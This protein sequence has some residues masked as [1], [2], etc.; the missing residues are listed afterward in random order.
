MNATA[1]IGKAY[2]LERLTLEEGEILF[3]EGYLYDL[4]ALAN[5]LAEQKVPHF[6]THATFVVDRN[7]NYTN[8]CNSLCKFCAFYRLPGDAKEGYVR[9]MDEIFHKIEELVAIGGTQ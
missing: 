4:A 8:Y 1:I 9:T 6:R 2:G 3:T 5:F 7:I